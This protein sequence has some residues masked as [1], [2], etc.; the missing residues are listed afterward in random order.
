MS[1]SQD[2]PWGFPDSRMPTE[3]ERQ[4]LCRMLYYALL[5]IRALGHEGKSEQAHSLA[6]AFHNL[7]V[8]LWS[9]AFSFSFFRQFLESYHRMYPARSDLFDYLKML[10]QIRE[11]G[12]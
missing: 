10:D 9:D 1:E 11:E 3:H 2:K 7:P 4:Q 8:Y 6:D 5:E 12:V